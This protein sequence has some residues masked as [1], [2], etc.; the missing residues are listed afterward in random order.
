MKLTGN[1]NIPRY[2]TKEKDDS[3]F[4]FLEETQTE[5]KLL[6]THLEEVRHI[7]SERG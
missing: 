1:I 6:C 5:C 4:F 2:E 7:D 3:A